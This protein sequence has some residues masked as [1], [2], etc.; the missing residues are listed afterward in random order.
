MGGTHDHG[1]TR[2]SKVLDAKAGLT[3]AI[4]ESTMMFIDTRHKMKLELDE[5][6]ELVKVFS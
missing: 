6:E 5:V 1:C 3:C 2:N 4:S